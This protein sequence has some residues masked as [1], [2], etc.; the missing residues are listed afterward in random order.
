LLLRELCS[1]FKDR[2]PPDCVDDAVVVAPAR[3]TPIDQSA[4]D[5]AA[6]VLGDQALNEARLL[7]ALRDEG[8]P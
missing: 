7:D 4:V 2:A 3:R 6:Q 1:N 5:R 8:Q